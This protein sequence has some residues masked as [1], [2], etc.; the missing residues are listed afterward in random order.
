MI[1]K[2][3]LIISAT[4][5][6]ETLGIAGA[7]LKYQKNGSFGLEDI[8]TKVKIVHGIRNAVLNLLRGN[9]HPF[10]KLALSKNFFSK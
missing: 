7:K 6:D 10:S 8:K 9:F 1:T 3:I 4:H 2:N 5:N